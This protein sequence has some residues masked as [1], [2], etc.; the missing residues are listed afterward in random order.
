MIAVKVLTNMYKLLTSIQTSIYNNNDKTTDNA[1][2]NQY[3]NK[4]VITIQYTNVV[5]YIYINS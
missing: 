5:S 2:Y 4:H 1:Q 3:D